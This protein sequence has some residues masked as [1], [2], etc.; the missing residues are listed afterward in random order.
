MLFH[1]LLKMVRGLPHADTKSIRI[2]RSRDGA[3]IVT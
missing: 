2:I 3:A 1:L